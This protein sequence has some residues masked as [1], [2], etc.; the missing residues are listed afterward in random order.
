VPPATAEAIQMTWTRTVT[1]KQWGDK[2]FKV[3]ATASNGAHVIYSADGG[4][5]IG[6]SNGTVTIN[7]AGSCVITAVA[8]N[9][10]PPATASLSFEIEPAHPVINFGKDSTRFQR[11]MRL[12]LSATTDPE[13]DLSY[14]VVHGANG[15]AHDEECAIVGSSLVWAHVPSLDRFPALD[16]FCMVKVTAARSSKNYVAPDPVQALIHIDYPVW[17]VHA[18]AQ[19]ISFADGDT[20]AVTVFEDTANALGMEVDATDGPCG[21]AS[22]GGKIPLGTTKYKLQVQVDDPADHPELVDA[23]GAYTCTMHASALPSA[24]QHGAKGK[25]EVAFVLTV[26]P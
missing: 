25:A 7:S 20:Q 22:T 14:A 15:S 26:T 12:A 24:W 2:P 3:L 4:C 8:A 10:D 18:Q 16:A 23:N 9:T 6:K 13:I 1:T 19:T 17:D 11:D 21:S 5:D